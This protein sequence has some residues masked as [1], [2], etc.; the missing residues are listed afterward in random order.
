MMARFMQVQRFFPSCLAIHV[1]FFVGLN[2]VGLNFAGEE[3][4]PDAQ[5]QTQSKYTTHS[6][7]GKVVWLHEAMARRHNMKLSAEAAERV[8]A[9]ETPQGDLIP[10]VEDKRGGSFRL[11]KR[12]RG[13]DVELLVRQYEGSPFVQVIQIFTLKK[14]GKYELDYWCEICSIAMFEL[15][16]CDCCQEDIIL[17]ERKVKN[18]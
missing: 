7:R 3:K 15:K 12:L 9:L 2:L 10:I 14:D 16:P 5:T 18:K 6:I 1:C 11:D 8:L 13:I 17:R 4:S